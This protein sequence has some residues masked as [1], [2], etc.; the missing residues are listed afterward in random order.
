M[1]KQYRYTNES[2]SEIGIRPHSKKEEAMIK[3]H[4]KSK[5][6]TVIVGK[7]PVIPVDV[8]ESKKVKVVRL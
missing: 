5:G 1:L 6:K 7:D 4:L 8:R 2:P 3:K